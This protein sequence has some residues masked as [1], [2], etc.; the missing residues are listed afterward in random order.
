MYRVDSCLIPFY[1]T[2]C[3]IYPLNMEKRARDVNDVNHNDE[4]SREQ[5]I[6]REKEREKTAKKEK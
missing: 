5:S 1:S 6:K 4:F 2:K 3:F